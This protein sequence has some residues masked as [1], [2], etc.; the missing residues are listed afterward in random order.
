MDRERL[1]RL[2]ARLQRTL[3]LLVADDD[4]GCRT[5]LV[6][7][8]GQI[9]FEVL[10]AQ[11]GREALTILRRSGADLSVMDINMPGM[12]GIEVLNHVRTEGMLLPCIFVSAEK[13][14]EIRKQAFS[15]GADSFIDKPVDVEL[16]LR[17]LTLCL[18]RSYPENPHPDAHPPKRDPHRPP[19]SSP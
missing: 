14:L 3:R 5:S 4:E 11:D 18:H 16:L 15:A 1:Q 12:T 19:E 10:C 7:F 8:F 9:G 13:S 17:S 6:D 2:Q